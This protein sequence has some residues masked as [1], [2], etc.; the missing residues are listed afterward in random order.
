[1]ATDFKDEEEF[2]R[3]IAITKKHLPV[4]FRVNP[5]YPNYQKLVQMLEDK[6]LMFGEFL[7]PG[8][9]TDEQYKDHIEKYDTD[10]KNI[11]LKK[12]EWYPSGLVY[13]LNMSRNGLKKAKGI[14]KF[15]RLIQVGAD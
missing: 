6:E 4:S 1:L 2:N 12:A 8:E 7:N 13:Y 15:H 5:V 10:L 9:L 3:F 14:K 11:Q